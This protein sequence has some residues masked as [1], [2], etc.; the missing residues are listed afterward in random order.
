MNVL[1]YNYLQPEESGGGGVNVYSKNLAAG[2][3][4]AGHRVIVLSSGD[5]YTFTNRHTWLRTWHDSYERAV[6]VNSPLLAP[7]EVAFD[8]LRQ[9]V[10]NNTLD[11]V[12]AL[13]R[14]KFGEI[15]VFHFQNVEGLTRSFFEQIRVDFPKSKIIYSIHN[16]NLV[17]PQV[18]LWYQDRQ[19]CTDYREGVACTQCPVKPVSSQVIRRS[20]R[21]RPLVQAVTR[22]APQIVVA[23]KNAKR[24]FTTWRKKVP[25]AGSLSILQE[26]DGAQYASFR[27]ANI[28]LCSQIFDYVLAVSKRTR[29]VVIERGLQ[30]HNIAV[31]YIGT[32]HKVIFDQ[33][34]KIT[35]IG[36]GLHIAYLGYMRPNKGFHFLLDVLEKLPDDVASSISLTIAAKRS[37]DPVAYKRLVKIALRFAAFHFYDGFTHDTLDTVLAG[38]NLGIVPPM[39]EDNLPQVAIEMVSRGIPVLTSDRG[40]AQEIADN[41]SFV[42]EAGSAISLQQRLQQFSTRDVLLGRFWE[43]PIRIYSM[44]EHVCDLTQYYTSSER[45]E[46][47]SGEQ[48]TLGRMEGVP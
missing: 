27:Q 38:V 29:Q 5:V 45:L 21:R 6:I 30:E 40:G 36:K 14:E 18:D 1:I 10:T 20:R 19:V 17:C 23:L 33:A 43:N 47:K 12:P 4:A 3:H 37:H 24:S 28:D 7:A 25:P 48:L 34:T 44:E 13:L 22:S 26:G 2:L 9:Y 41:P 16:Y 46:V 11:K 8:D 15:D 35:D 31:S 42:F 32:A 39:W